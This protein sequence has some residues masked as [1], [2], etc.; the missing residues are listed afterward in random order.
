MNIMANW[1]NV[2]G[3]VSFVNCDPLFHG[4]SSNWDILPA[5]P[6]WLTGHLLRKDC[7]VAPIPAADYAI[8]HSEFILLPDIGIASD[9]DVGSVLL[10]SKNELNEINNIALP[11]DSSTSKKLLIYLLKQLEIFPNTTEMGPDLDQMLEKC[12]AALLIGDRALDEAERYPELV[13]LDLGSEW[14]KNTGLPMVFAVFAAPKDS[15]DDDLRRA[16]KELLTNAINFKNNELY[17]NEVISSTSERSGFEHDRV[18]KYFRQVTNI[19]DENAVNG[20]EIFLKEVCEMNDSV[21]WFK[22]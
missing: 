21:N 9:G 4:L 18:E 7:L 20:L 14:K 17:K 12:D 2:I 22:P 13:K 1:S 16:H 10:F 3:R 6:S 19:L 11:S 5:P 15:D 8:N